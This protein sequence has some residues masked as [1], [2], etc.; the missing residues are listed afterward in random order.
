MKSKPSTT[1]A[2][3]KSPGL[4]K[5][6]FRRRILLCVTGLTPQVVTETV[7]ALARRVPTFV[8]TE[9][10]IITTT[11]GANRALQLVDPRH[12]QLAK[13]CRQYRLPLPLCDESTIHVI[14]Q[15]GTD[16]ADMRSAEENDAAADSILD[17]V[18]RLTADDLCQVHF[19]IAGGRKTMGFYLGYCASLLGRAQD[20]MSHVLVNAP[21]ENLPAFFFP[22]Q[23]PEVLYD[24]RK[25]KDDPTNL[26]HSTSDAAVDLAS[27]AFLR[28]R[29]K[30]PPGLLQTGRSFSETV[31][32]LNSFQ[33]RPTLTLKILPPKLASGDAQYQVF[34]AG[35]YE[36]ELSPTNFALLW[37]FAKL[38]KSSSGPQR[39]VDVEA[40][41]DSYRIIALPVYGAVTGY[42]TRWATK[43]T[44]SSAASGQ[45]I[46][47]R[48]QVDKLNKQLR[49]R[50][51]PYSDKTHGVVATGRDARARYGM[52][53]PAAAIHLEGPDESSATGQ[54]W[55]ISRIPLQAL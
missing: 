32:L 10:H 5:S 55:L 30:L 15:P 38:A 36:V 44:A 6:D 19:S 3:V 31:G 49:D 51:G 4:S 14:R 40:W 41:L 12:G 29:E 11:I 27:V 33:G 45:Q 13:L 50:L 20:D 28:L 16:L 26:A 18:R 34:V 46:E 9:V 7:Y 2:R 21:F 37:M 42:G 24:T 8:P 43:Q 25:E 35:G 1:I 22:P 54:P 48:N 47:L 52:S 39:M 17:V 23:P 53:L